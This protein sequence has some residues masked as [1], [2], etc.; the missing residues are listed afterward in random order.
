MSRMTNRVLAW[1]WR[2]ILLAVALAGVGMIVV[3]LVIRHYEA[4][5]PSV[6]ELGH[7][8]PP[9]VTRILA[10]D[11]SLLGEEFV[12]RRTVVPLR[13]IPAHVKLAFLAAEDASFYEHQGLDYPGMLRAIWKNLRGSSKQGASTITQQVIKN[14]VLSSERTYERKIKEVILA[15]RVEAEL[16]KDTLL[17]LYMNG[18]YFGH[19]RYGV[20]EAA[21]YYFGKSVKD[22]DLAE[23][24]TLAAIPKGPTRYSP[25][26]FPE[27]AI[28]R[29]DYVLA[30]MMDKGFIK[31]EVGAAAKASPLKLAPEAVVAPE[32]APEVLSEVKRE[33]RSL[34]GDEANRGGFTITTTIDPELQRAT[35]QALRD[36]LAAYD[37]RKFNIAP[38]KKPKPKAMPKLFE[39]DPIA[40]KKLTYLGEVIQGNDERNEIT[41]R[42]GNLRGVVPLDAS[43]FNPDKIPASQFADP[44]TPVRVSI[45]SPG[46]KSASGTFEHATLRLE[47]GPEGGIVVMNVG[48]R[49]ILAIAGGFEAARGAFDRTDQAR[50]QPG[51][52]FKTFVYSYGLHSHEMTAASILPADPAVLDKK[53]K[54]YDTKAPIEP[55]RLREALATSVN[56]SAQW[57]GEKLGPAKVAAWANE[58][59]I[60]SK[61]GATPSLALGAYE[62]T[63]RELVNAYATFASGG[64]VASPRLIQRIVA[65]SGREVALPVPAEPHRAMTEAEAFL[66]TD[67][68]RT[69]VERGTGR[70]A[71]VLGR[72]IAGKTGTSNQAKDAWFVGYSTD[73]VCGVW[74]GFDDASPLGAGET[75]GRTSLPAFIDVMKKAHERLPI[76]DFPT[77]AGV[78]RI[79]IDPKTGLLP[80]VEQTDAIEEWFIAGTEPTEIAKE[81]APPEGQEKPVTEET[82]GER[83]E[84]SPKP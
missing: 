33:L 15:R 20:E 71:K 47:L 39:G 6:S 21:R 9:Q 50:R 84:L 45:A 69:V 78:V 64:M 31:P 3:A 14:M 24:A 81:S 54:N 30:Q 61:L 55:L 48:N 7:Y 27:R 60:T 26:N 79:K 23:A 4:G 76:T 56:V 38:L 57:S 51:S 22:L 82:E 43:R 40:E 68:L 67:L 25:R 49:E 72:P 53:I 35:R 77:P 83:A 59:G 42:V 29:R 11:G 80:R 12:E 28:H 66:T 17:E 2:G 1:L 36:N 46:P 34:V 13:D 41:V 74:T 70:S 62:V 73:I 63:P 65:P 75:G 10:R 58:S 32:L 8:E 44:G 19:G 18:I 5:L 37:K 16:S 52:T